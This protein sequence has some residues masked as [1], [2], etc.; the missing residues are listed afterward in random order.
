MDAEHLLYNCVGGVRWGKKNI[1]GLYVIDKLV[2]YSVYSEHS[3]VKKV[4]TM[5]V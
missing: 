2:K 4:F 1:L 3:N 5:F